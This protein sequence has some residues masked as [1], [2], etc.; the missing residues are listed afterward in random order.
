MK[1]KRKTNK[2]E[3]E[4]TKR[5]GVKEEKSE[6]AKWNGEAWI[7]EMVEESKQRVDWESNNGAA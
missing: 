4:T 7:D 5:K 6:S 1:R 3:R 2:K